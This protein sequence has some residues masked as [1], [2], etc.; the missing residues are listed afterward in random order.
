[1]ELCFS[2][3]II[4]DIP[5]E[6][7]NTLAKKIIRLSEDWTTVNP[8]QIVAYHGKMKILISAKKKELRTH[9]HVQMILI[10]NSFLLFSA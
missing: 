1:M 6:A 5:F 7:V 10:L 8:C 4:L 9:T 3:A 2:P